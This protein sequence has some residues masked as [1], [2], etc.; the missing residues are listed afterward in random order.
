MLTGVGLRDRTKPIGKRME[1]VAHPHRVAILYLLAHENFPMHEIAE[2]IDLPLNLVSHHL[3]I[4]VKTGW[5]RKKKTGKTVRYM[6]KA[7]T[8]RDLGTFFLNTPFGKENFP[9]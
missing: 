5:I 7:R 9:S 3:A 1:G 8:F 2:T 6:L 4:L